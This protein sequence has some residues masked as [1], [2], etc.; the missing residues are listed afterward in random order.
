MSYTSTIAFLDDKGQTQQAEL[1]VG[2]YKEAEAKGVTVPQLINTKFKT[3]STKFGSA[4]NQM[5]MNSGIVTKTD[6]EMGLH[7]TKLKDI[8][9]GTGPC[10]ASVVRDAV[11]GS[12]ILFPAA[13]LETVDSYLRT[14]SSGDLA[15]FN[16]MVAIQDTVANNR[17]E[18]PILNYTNP[19]A[20]RSTQIAQ[21]AKPASMM[22]LTTSQVAKAIPT[23]SLGLTISNEALQAAT[24]DFVG[25][26]LARQAEVEQAGWVDTWIN[27]FLNGDTDY[28][29]A[30]LATTKAVT[31][32][33]SIA[34]SGVL[35]QKAWVKWLRRNTKKR[36]IDWIICDIDTYLAIETRSGK[37]VI[38]G[39]DP[40]S[41]R[42]DAIPS[43][44]NL[45]MSNPKVYIVETGV[46]PANTII[47]LDSRYAIRKVTNAN[48]SYS[49]VEQLV[50]QRG[51]E[52]RFD[53]GAI[54][55]R[56]YDDAW[57]V[58]TLVYP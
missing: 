55:T 38:T 6:A 12:R 58:L 15:I 47:G 49:A 4:F 57:D 31:L 44:A 8:F 23:Y 27:S 26:S 16:S 21:L 53:W 10:A 3:D 19:E 39:D 46:I 24:F 54:A 40:N 14:D 13:V 30:A 29:T 22:T 34:A 42:M 20:A 56:I 25:L 7:S 28:G 36:V 9:E 45:R 37:P 5:L 1:S 52:M 11:P 51:Q 17:Y 50:M 48:A 33:S 35:T 2:V 32:D 18:Q 41:P 43:V